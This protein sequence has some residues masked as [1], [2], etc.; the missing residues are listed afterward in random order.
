[1]KY[2]IAFLLILNLIPAKAEPPPLSKPIIE[3]TTPPMAPNKKIKIF[4][5]DTAKDKIYEIEEA[6]NAWL[7]E[8][9]G[10]AV[11]DTHIIQQSAGH[12]LVVYH[13]LDVP[14]TNMPV[15]PK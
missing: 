1:M 14:V 7:A 8:D 6:V 5:Y 4:R 15:L 10:R 2:L 3:A 9:N 13:Y 12:I 11:I